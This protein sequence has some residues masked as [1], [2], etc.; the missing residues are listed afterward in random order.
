MELQLDTGVTVH[1]EVRGSGPA[2]VLL[3][4]VMMSGRFFHEQLDGA[5]P[6]SFT[7]VAPD[8]R[9]HGQSEK[10]HSGHTVAGYA[11]DV[12]SLLIALQIE[13]PV[14]VGWSMGAMVAWEYVKEFGSDSIAGLVVVDQPPS[15]FAWDGYPFGLMTL[16][17]LADN[18]E[19]LQGDQRAVAQEFADLMQHVPDDSRTAWIV[20]EILKV[21]ASIASTI[22]TDQTLR[23]Y[24]E[25]LGT[26]TCPTLVA[27]GADPKM[28]DPAAGSF[29]IE[30]TLGAEL[31]VFDESSH[32]PFL[33]EPAEFDRV[34]SEW[35]SRLS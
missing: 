3:P 6:D 1:V 33:E 9:G 7:V 35:A 14:L 20:E 11:R 18:V 23:D 32:M 22:L 27:F 19:A 24:R 4:G 21:P 25:V 31:V 8:Y 5:L 15:D 17:G 13:R 30:R 29:I 2:L 28:T 12:R 34:L 26:I 10:V 16:A